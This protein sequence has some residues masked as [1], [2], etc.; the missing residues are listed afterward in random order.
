MVYCRP[1]DIQYNV[2]ITLVR[3]WASALK[4][5]GFINYQL[6]IINYQLSIINYQGNQMQ[7]QLLKDRY[8]ILQPLGQGGF[9]K[10]YLAEDTQKPSHPQ[11]VVKHLQ[12]QP[13]TPGAPIPPAVLAKAQQLFDQEAKILEKLG[14]HDQIPELL[15]Y[16]EQNNEFYLVQELINGDT[17]SKEIIPGQKLSETQVISLLKDTL[18]VLAF[19]HQEEVIHRDIKPANLMRRQDDGKIILIDFGAV[20]DIRGLSA[21]PQGAAPTVAIGTYGYMPSE[22][23]G[24]QPKLSSDVYALGII[25]IQALTGL[26]PDPNA[27]GL[28]KDS[29]T[30]EISWRN[31][32]T[33]SDDLAH[34]IDKMVLQ[35]YR[36][37]Y[38][39][40]GAALQAILALSNSSTAPT[41]VISPKSPPKTQISGKGNQSTLMSVLNWSRDHQLGLLAV[42]VGVI[43]VMTA[44]MTVPEVRELLGLDTIKDGV[45]TEKG[46]TLKYPGTW[47]VQAIN[48]P[49]GG[50]RAVFQSPKQDSSDP[51]QENITLTILDLP[52]TLTKEQYYEQWLRPQLEREYNIKLVNTPNSTTLDNRDANT[53]IYTITENGIELKRQAIW[54]V[55]NGTVYQIT[56]SGETG[57][58]PTD[59]Q[60]VLK[61]VQESLQLP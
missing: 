34:I 17:L 55:K 31:H 32:A 2:A 18:E 51:Y 37:R 60:T 7:G 21:N 26:N 35:D 14:K 10:T 29:T 36:Q 28:P 43:G 54:T 25:A 52:Q 47:Q 33:V 8:L 6:S 38:P 12:V 56:Y 50:D 48:P 45:Y 61:K 44:A 27:G 57:N 13:P 59:Q 11:C 16:V 20:K 24:G 40:A 46:M 4:G 39:D 58:F 23:A 15:A 49:V 53:V 5:F 3:S 9:G 42:L 19:V 30:G 1:E 22:Q 41:A